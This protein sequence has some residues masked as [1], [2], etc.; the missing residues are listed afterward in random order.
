M[1]HVW[2]IAAIV[3]GLSPAAAQAQQ[4]G[5]VCIGPG[6]AWGY[7]NGYSSEAGAYDRAMQGSQYDCNEVR[8]FY[9]TCGAIA[10][11]TNGG[12]GWS[13]GGSRGSAEAG[14]INYCRQYGSG[15]RV[16]V[17]ACSG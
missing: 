9:N 7:A 8:T 10:V 15:C 11:A 6:G 16:A 1:K 4:W 3:I 14:A 13:T 5:A 12:W 2:K 17:W